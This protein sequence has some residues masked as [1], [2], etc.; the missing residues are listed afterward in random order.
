MGFSQQGDDRLSAVYFME[1]SQVSRQ[2]RT[3]EFDA[4]L[5]GYVGLSDLAET[6]VYAVYVQLTDQLGIEGLVFFR[7]YFDEEGRADGQWNVPLDRL[8]DKG[9]KGPDLGDGPVR[10][11]CRSHCPEKRY[12]EDLW[13]PDMTPGSNHFQAIRKAVADNRL[14]LRPRKPEPPSGSHI[15]VLDPQSEQAAK[16]PV[17]DSAE[18]A[19]LAQMIREYRLRI[20]TLKSVHRDA[21]AEIR[22]EHSHEIQSLRSEMQELE[23]RFERLRLSNEQLKQR[24]AERNEQYLGLQEQLTEASHNSAESSQASD[25]ETVLLREQL[26][27]K[28]RELEMRND[29]VV[30]LEQERD[31]W[32][33]QEPADD[34][35]MRHIQDQS[36]F[37]VAYHPGVGHIT[38]PYDDLNRYFDNPQAYAAEKCGVSEQAYRLWLAHHDDPTCQAETDNGPCGEP[39]MRIGQP[40]EFK[41]GVHDRCQAHQA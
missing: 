40:G 31:A 20:R 22:R 12:T 13:D 11:I 37:M 21:M 30:Q 6:E 39:L 27:R 41:P 28:Q 26:E 5:D 32:A 7:I 4:F 10:L 34:A 1:G 25:A 33:R 38:L 16:P 35:L 2:M 23:Q 3:S 9:A 24:L 8:A 18:R 14:R 15:P 19:R 36:L 29:Q 17:S